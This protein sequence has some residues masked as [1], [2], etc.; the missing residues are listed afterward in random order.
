MHV[1]LT[2]SVPEAK[3]I[4]DAQDKDMLRRIA[5]QNDSSQYATFLRKTDKL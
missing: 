5:P 4:S 3:N 1:I 2:E